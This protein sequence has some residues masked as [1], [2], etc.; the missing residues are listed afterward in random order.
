LKALVRLGEVGFT[1]N[2]PRRRS[3]ASS[4]GHAGGGRV[5]RRMDHHD[6]RRPQEGIL[7]VS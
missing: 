2:I 3:D 6:K 7:L 1:H 5:S 4:L